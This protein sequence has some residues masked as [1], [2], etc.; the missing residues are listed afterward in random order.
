MKRVLI[1]IL[2]I[3]IFFGQNV[4]LAKEENGKEKDTPP[5]DIKVLIDRA[6]EHRLKDEKRSMQTLDEARKI[7][8][9][10]ND[11]ISFF[12][13]EKCS[14]LI[15]EDNNR[16][17]SALTHYQIALNHA[18]QLGN[19]NFRATI[20]N[21]IAIVNKRMGKYKIA[22]DFYQKSMEVAHQTK[23]LQ[24]E[25][26]SYHGL[27]TLYE[28]LGDYEKAIES[29]WASIRIAE[30][31]KSRSG[32]VNTMQNIAIT[33][34]KLS[35]NQ[36]AL[37][38]I[39]KA[40]QLSLQENDTL[41]IGSV[42]FDY[43]KVLNTSGN[44]DQALL[45]FNES[46]KLFQTVNLK[47]LIARCYFY[48]ADTYTS[49]GEY[50]LAQTYF[51]QCSDYKDFISIKSYTELNSKL[52]ALYLKL[53]KWGEAEKYFLISFKQADKYQLRDLKKESALNLAKIYAHQQNF[54]RAY[55]FENIASQLRDSLYNEAQSKG[56]TELQFKYD[57]EKSEK[58]IQALKLKQT[59]FIL[60]FGG[61]LLLSIIFV[62]FYIIRLR[63]RNNRELFLKNS[64]IEGQNRL[65][66]EKN[67][68]LEQFAYAA[69]HDLKEPLRS[70]GSFANLLQRRY[71]NQ[72][73]ESA[74]EYM[75]FIVNG[76]KRMND[77]LV[78]LLNFSALTSQVADNEEVRL[79]DVLEVVKSNLKTSIEDKEA[80]IHI[81]NNLPSIP[82]HH[83]HLVQLFQ[84]LLSN[85]L[86]FTERKPRI[87]IS[88]EDNENEVIISIADNGIGMDQ[89]YESKVFRLFHRL[90][91]NKN[92]E[93]SGVGL[94]IC[95]N[96]VE[97]YGG[98]IWYESVIGE[99]TTFFLAIP[100][101]QDAIA[102]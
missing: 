50:A 57:T 66:M 13:I 8:A 78:G 72:L 98:R 5:S 102:A 23:D 40:Y 97:K 64:Q 100:K 91:K 26:F 84:N 86:K 52:G 10:K 56:I 65:L 3:N 21:D 34:T 22:K 47:P 28:T 60:I 12:H 37:E 19:N 81:K 24:S 41:L 25:E 6:L 17:D 31:R 49:K 9:I 69:A 36:T 45:K 83:L 94:S 30:E 101:Q 15:F 67:A 16:L 82:M 7:A 58:E 93:G 68:A 55:Q 51:L 48:I 4:L 70:I 38:T 35:N 27:G 39:E 53:D 92:Y 88:S 90:N 29:Y 54:T 2:I 43:G 44:A 33:Y 63:G 79:F 76:A 1:I 89:A 73:D 18:N 74:Q 99:G 71:K 61:I 75:A 11:W 42:L 62:S 80:E 46:L 20:Y 96:I 85:S 32:V 14:G 77:L 95:K 87:E 59:E